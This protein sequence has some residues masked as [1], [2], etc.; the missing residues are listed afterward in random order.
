MVPSLPT[1]GAPG[2]SDNPIYLHFDPNNRKQNSHRLKLA[3]TSNNRSDS[4]T[5]ADWEPCSRP[6]GRLAGGA[7]A[8][9]QKLVIHLFHAGHRGG[10]APGAL[11]RGVA[12]GIAAQGDHALGGLDFDLGG[13]D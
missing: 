12:G 4:R 5:S 11:A 3:S 9:H 13:A 6:G 8:A 2:P 1:H 7:A 10:H